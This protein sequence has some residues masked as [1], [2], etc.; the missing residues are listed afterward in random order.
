MSMVPKSNL[1]SSSR[2]RRPRAGGGPLTP[3]L[4]QFGNNLPHPLAIFVH[5]VYPFH[6]SPIPSPARKEAPHA[7]R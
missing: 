5:F 2:P 7:N 3:L 6:G 1:L 4:L